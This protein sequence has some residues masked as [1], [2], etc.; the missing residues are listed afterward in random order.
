MSTN[1]IAPYNRNQEKRFLKA[2]KKLKRF[3]CDDIYTAIAQLTKSEKQ[4][5]NFQITKQTKYTSL[6]PSQQHIADSIGRHRETVNKA[7]GNLHKLEMVFKYNRGFMNGRPRSNLY[8]VNP[9]FFDRYLVE[10]LYVQLPALRWFRKN[11]TLVSKVCDI[12]SLYKHPITNKVPTLEKTL[13]KDSYSSKRDE[14]QS[15]KKE[16][17]TKRALNILMELGLIR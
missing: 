2:H 4:V 9:L 8:R 5:L 3:Q 13:Y 6:Y 17:N 15:A 11:P 16:E 12:K 1:N 10:A 14:L 7:C